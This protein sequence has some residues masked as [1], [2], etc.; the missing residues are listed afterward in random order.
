MNF[1]T[2]IL[3][4]IPNI[5][6]FYNSERMKC[7][8]TSTASMN[9]YC[10]FDAIITHKNKY[11][12]VIEV[13]TI[14]M[15]FSKL[16]QFALQLCKLHLAKQN[17]PFMLIVKCSCGTVLMYRY[18]KSHSNFLVA[19]CGNYTHGDVASDELFFW[20]PIEKFKILK[21]DGI[22][23]LQKF[24]IKN[25]DHYQVIDETIMKKIPVIRSL[26]IN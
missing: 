9:R 25:K 7:S 8:I 15:P 14:S 17:V 2:Q 23:H 11:L 10:N 5:I 13:K 6:F 19:E 4:E 16:K 22:F 26:P 18:K 20:I 12:G 21:S 3:A 1:E 24:Y